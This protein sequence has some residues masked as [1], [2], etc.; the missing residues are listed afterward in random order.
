MTRYYYLFQHT[1]GK[2]PRVSTGRAIR[3][4][5]LS[6]LRGVVFKLIEKEKKKPKAL[7]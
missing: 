2:T 6:I 7:I 1:A 3:A 5:F 4:T